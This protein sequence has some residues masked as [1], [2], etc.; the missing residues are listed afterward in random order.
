MVHCRYV[1]DVRAYD[2]RRFI[3][4]GKVHGAAL[5]RFAHS[6]RRE[7]FDLV[8]APATVSLSFTT[9]IL[10]W[11]TRAPVRCG[12][13]RLNGTP[14]PSAALYTHPAV[15]D[16][17][18]DPGRHQTLRHFDVA[19]GIPG[20]REP[21]D[22]R[23]EITL[24]APEA[25]RGRGEALLLRGSRTKL[26]VVHPGAGKP[27]NRWPAE[28]FAAVAERLAATQDAAIVITAGPM[29]DEPVAGMAAAL[30]MPHTVLCRRPIREVAAVL[31]QADLLISND[32]GIMHVGA[33]AGAPVLSL[34]GP[35][36]AAEWAPV[37]PR[38]RF[39][40]GEGGNIE[41]IPVE[42]VME[43][44]AAMLNSPGGGE[45]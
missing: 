6:L 31:A 40:Q 35:T 3:G 17:R 23:S 44:A 5:V 34:F 19:A 29:D 20:L 13:G 30:A 21:T 9:D 36:P 41:V 16:W 42:A 10:V 25:E 39:L 12:V 8:I 26:V 18:E 1:D 32:T 28:R 33:A 24:T 14:N 43:T 38:H 37:G 2:K 7:G 45:R 15:L 22:L 4:G 27:P 11:L